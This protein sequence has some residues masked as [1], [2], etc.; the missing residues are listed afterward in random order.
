MTQ[1]NNPGDVDE[2]RAKWGVPQ[3]LGSEEKPAAPRVKRP[4]HTLGTQS[5]TCESFCRDRRP[6]G[7]QE[8]AGSIFL[9]KKGTT[10]AMLV[11]PVSHPGFWGPLLPSP[12]SRGRV[13][14]TFFS[15]SLATAEWWGGKCTL[16]C[17]FVTSCDIKWASLV[18]QLLKNPPA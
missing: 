8:V 2:R 9:A 15:S 4:A 3:E 12:H 7:Q 16:I 18:A 17:G 14:L 1:E 6:V 13:F 5:G 11:P 10:Q